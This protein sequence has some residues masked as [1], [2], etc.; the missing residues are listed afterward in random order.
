MRTLSFFILPQTKMKQHYPK[1]KS[2]H[3]C[4]KCGKGFDQHQPLQAQQRKS[5]CRRSCTRCK[6]KFQ[7]CTQ[8]SKHQINAVHK[9]CG[10]CNLNICRLI[11][12]YHH[13][14]VDHQIN[15][16]KCKTCGKE[17]KLFYDLKKHVIKAV[18][19]A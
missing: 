10:V 2:N 9:S 14:S 5:S 7:T 1:R 17:H 3:F 15:P 16:R 12:Y 19:Q 11:D 4:L 18:Q 8:L 6:H 13:Q